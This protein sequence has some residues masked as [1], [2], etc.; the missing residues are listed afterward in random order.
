MIPGDKIG[1]YKGRTGKKAQGR[2]VQHIQVRFHFTPQMSR[3][4]LELTR[5][6]AASHGWWFES[7]VPRWE[8]EGGG[9]EKVRRRTAVHPFFFFLFYRMVFNGVGGCSRSRLS[10]SNDRPAAAAATYIYRSNFFC[11]GNL[12][13]CILQ[14]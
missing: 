7:S 11:C 4:G 6:R 2:H 8:R 10:A 13:V 14:K 9:G 1:W 5:H 3:S 12:H